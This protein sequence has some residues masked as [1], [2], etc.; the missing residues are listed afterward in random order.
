MQSFVERFR[1][2]LQ[3]VEIPRDVREYLD[4]IRQPGEPTM[5]NERFRQ[6]MTTLF[7][8]ALEQEQKRRSNVSFL[9]VV[10]ATTTKFTKRI[11]RELYDNEVDPPTVDAHALL[12]AIINDIIARASAE[13]FTEPHQDRG[14]VVHL[15]EYRRR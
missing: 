9:D 11:P 4:T 2:I 6:G 8:E 15:H 7:L 5:T 12:T 10:S 13:H 14:N 1:D 3:N